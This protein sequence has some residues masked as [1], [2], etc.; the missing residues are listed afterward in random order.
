MNKMLSFINTTPFFT[1]YFSKS[2]LRVREPPALAYVR[3]SKK[4]SNF[5]QTPELI[6]GNDQQVAISI[7]T[8][9]NF[10]KL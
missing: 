9:L 2:K 1:I 4:G 3:L 7:R 10:L 6:K 8:N 5:A